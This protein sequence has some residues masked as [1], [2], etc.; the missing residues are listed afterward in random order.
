MIDTNLKQ[1]ILL[2]AYLLFPV[3]TSIAYKLRTLEPNTK[4]QERG[5]W[6]FRIEVNG[7]SNVIR[8]L[9]KSGDTVFDVGVLHGT[10]SEIVLQTAPTAKVY[11]IEANPDL[12]RS[13]IKRLA[14][15]WGH[16]FRAYPKIN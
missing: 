16:N 6:D 9:V 1:Y 13:I 11:A 10:W 5:Y 12:R 2:A 3:N 7:E 15:K 8:G 14:K 4:N